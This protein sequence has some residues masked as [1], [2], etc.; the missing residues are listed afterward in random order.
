MF[1]CSSTSELA[2]LQIEIFARRFFFSY[3]VI[4]KTENRESL[5]DLLVHTDTRTLFPSPYVSQ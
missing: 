2:K 1:A 3:K 4:K 5:A